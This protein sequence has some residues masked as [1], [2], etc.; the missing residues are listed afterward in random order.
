MNK[1]NCS[2]FV[3]DIV[4]ERRGSGYTI[5]FVER[6]IPEWKKVT[7]RIKTSGANLDVPIIGKD[8]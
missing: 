2:D 1:S 6:F 7:T 8:R 3:R 4:N 5:E